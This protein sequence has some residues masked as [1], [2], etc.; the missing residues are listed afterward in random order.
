MIFNNIH[1]IF[2]IERGDVVKI[3]TYVSFNAHDAFLE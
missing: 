1:N 3:K 2:I